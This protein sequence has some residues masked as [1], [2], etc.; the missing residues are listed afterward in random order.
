MRDVRDFLEFCLNGSYVRRFHQHSVVLPDINA[1]HSHGV[2]M[3]CYLLSPEDPSLNLIMAAL[4]HD[5]A[6]YAVGDVPAPTKRAL[7]I[8]DALSTIE[9]N[10]LE[11]R[12]LRFE[13]KLT[14]EEHRT[15]KMAD[16]LDGML[17]CVHELRLG[18]RTLVQ[19]Y[20]TWIT[21]IESDFAEASEFESLVMRT[22]TQMWKESL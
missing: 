16:A 4:T 19:P 14:V 9:G 3:L 12:G 21:W 7:G 6:E 8:R 15:L 11:T 2:A 17:Y 18:N 20:R 1:R 22:V 10:Q 13:D 5:L